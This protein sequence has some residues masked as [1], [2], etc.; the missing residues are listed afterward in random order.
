MLEN[1]RSILKL[2]K[3]QNNKVK[4]F[5]AVII[6]NSL[7]DSNS[8]TKILNVQQEKQTFV[9]PKTSDM[10]HKHVIYTIY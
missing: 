10:I 9:A 3:H 7:L 2:R 8:Q 6:T 4:E 1:S 5:Y